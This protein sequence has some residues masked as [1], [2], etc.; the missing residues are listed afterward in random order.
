MSLRFASPG[1]ALE[2]VQQT[3]VKVG[4]CFEPLPPPPQKNV[5]LRGEAGADKNEGGGV[6]EGAP[7]K[8]K[9]QSEGGRG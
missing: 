4:L 7:P 9:S 3:W 6:G 1:K 8:K 2:R 5:S